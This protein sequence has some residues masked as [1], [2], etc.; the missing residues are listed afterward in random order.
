MAIQPATKN[1]EPQ[2]Y[3]RFISCPNAASPQTTYV[4]CYNGESALIMSITNLGQVSSALLTMLIGE[5]IE[6]HPTHKSFTC[7]NLLCHCD[8][9]TRYPLGTI[10]NIG[11]VLDAACAPF[12]KQLVFDI[13][14]PLDRTCDIRLISEPI[15]TEYFD[16]ALQII[17]N[18][19]QA[20]EPF[21]LLKDYI[22]NKSLFF[23]TREVNAEEVAIIWASGQA[24][25]ASA[26]ASPR[27][28]AQ[29]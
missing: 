3:I 8:S 11:Q 27:P 6:V 24:S 15:N 25:V 16:T 2:Y 12:T 1:H 5:R 26:S 18:Y 17:Y 28:T 29:T 10:V 21:I 14:N 20:E 9:I 13:K 4:Q 23:K 22:I 7:N 19:I